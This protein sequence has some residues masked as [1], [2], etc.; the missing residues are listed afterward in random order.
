MLH[1]ALYI[2]DTHTKGRGVFTRSA[3]ASGE[4]LEIAPVIVLHEGDRKW[5]DKTRLHDYIFE[6]QPEGKDLCCVALGYV[7]I[8]NHAEN[9]NCTYEMSYE[10][11]TISIY[12]IREIDAG[13]E[14]CIN[15]NGD[16]YQ[17][18]RIWFKV[19]P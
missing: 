5:V 10:E 9:A 11:E 19:L 4:L 7:S 8:Y 1:P 14:L 17:S 3:L 16:P 6:W 18:D 2:A 13:E 15:Y 12:T